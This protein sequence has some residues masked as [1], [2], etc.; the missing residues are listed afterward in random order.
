MTDLFSQPDQPAEGALT[1]AELDRRC[2]RL[3]EG[4]VGPTWVKGEISGF[5]PYQSGHWYFTLKDQDA[6]IR[7][8]MWRAN[9]ARA[10]KPPTDGA[11]VFVFGTPT[12][13]EE[14]GEFRLT[15]TRFLALE[16]VGA[17]QLAFERT[18]KALEKDG[19][20]DPAR[21]R[22]LPAF[23]RTVA[24]VTSLDGAALHDIITVARKRWPAVRLIAIG[25]KV[26]G[27]EAEAEVVAALK[28]VD[29][30]EGIDVCIVG[31]GGGA[32]EDLDVFNR[33]S[34]C[35]ALA[36][37]GVP[38]VSAVGHETDISLTDLVADV[39]AATPSAAA[40]L[41]VP[42]RAIWWHRAQDLATRLA[43]ALTQRGRLARER[44]ARSADRLEAAL[45]DLLLDRRRHADRL[46]AQLD[47]L[48]PLKV[49]GR[50]YAV[51]TGAEGR[52]LKTVAD[53]EPGAAFTLRVSDG[54]VPARVEPT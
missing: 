52:V 47:A 53:F 39:R 20:F 38:T 28:R 7:C 16:G 19:L 26:Q 46:A 54:A 33:E 34:V 41:V 11:Q 21:K 4:E 30:L 35:R 14:R 12:V 40:E 1:V 24:V 25:T 13:W 37:V 43:G 18:K 27:S 42:D 9:A 15:V 17:Q 22:P 29:R 51:P 8:V 49:L 3:L 45:G 48:S 44:L 36:A 5:K 10:G 50:G 23:V 31:R 6:Q 2:R 32:R